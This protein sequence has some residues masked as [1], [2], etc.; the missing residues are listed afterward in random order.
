MAKEVKR[1][2]GYLPENVGFYGDMDAV[3]SLEY[4]ADLNGFKK[5]E[6]R[7]ASILNQTSTLW[8][9]LLAALFLRER[10]TLAK[11]FAVAAGLAGGILV[12]CSS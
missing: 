4:V 12:I 8:V 11:A 1:H 5:V 10:L 3:Q 6:A 2:V 9:V 7:T